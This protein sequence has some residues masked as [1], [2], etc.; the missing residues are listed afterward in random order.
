[1]FD[2]VCRIVR[3]ELLVLIDRTVGLRQLLEFLIRQLPFTIPRRDIAL[4][5]NQ[6]SPVSI[7]N[8][9]LNQSQREYLRTTGVVCDQKS[10]SRAEPRSATLP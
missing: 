10:T 4:P 2:C 1:M 3:R 5:R 7:T 6:F 8:T 9:G